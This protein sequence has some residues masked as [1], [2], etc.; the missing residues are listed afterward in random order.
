MGFE[1]EGRTGVRGKVGVPNRGVG[2]WISYR[3]FMG[4]MARIT[5]RGMAY[6]VAYIHTLS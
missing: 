4:V 2:E 6:M 1:L 5:C 3:H